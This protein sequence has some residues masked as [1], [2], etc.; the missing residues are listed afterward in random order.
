M[1]AAASSKQIY[2]AKE[3]QALMSRIWA[4]D[5]KDDP[6]AFVMYVYPWRKK[7]TPLE[8]MSGPRSWQKDVLCK[9]R[10]QIAENKRRIARGEV[11]LVLQVAISSGRGIGK[12]SLLA[13]ITHWQMSCVLGGMSIVTANTEDQLRSKTFGEVGKWLAL[14]INGHWFDKSAT[15]VRPAPWFAELLKSDLKI[16][17]GY[18]Y[19]Q[20]QTWSAE[21]PDAFAGAH[22]MNGTVVLMDEASGIDSTIW[23]VTEGFFTEPVLYRFWFVFSNPRRNTGS[24]FECFH[25]MR[26]FWWRLNIDSRKVEGTDKTVYDKIIAKY[27]EDSDEVRVEVKGEFPRQGDNQFIGRDLVMGSVERDLFEDEYAGL[28]MGV[29]PA[30]FGEDMT[31]VC[32]RRGRDCR[33]IP[34]IGW[35]GKDNMWVANMCAELIDKHGPDAVVVDAGNGTGIID[36]LR[37]MGYKVHEA[38]FGAKAQDEAY[39]NKR[40]ELWAKMRDWLNEGCLPNKAELIDDL[41]GPEYGFQGGGDKIILESKEKMKSRGLSSPDWADALACTFAVKVARLDSKLS[42]SKKNKQRV[43]KDM[44]FRF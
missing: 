29:D 5:I 26:Q 23:T 38:W 41:V 24:F 34:M 6:Y 19:C 9:M 31:T 20:A 42:R 39:A 17:T 44:D 22:N 11:P 40:T 35:K 2:S 12:S 25:K 27:G 7:G 33:S 4:A 10:D 3:E 15:A 1:S 21:N 30:R 37:E 32:F 13:W 8:K 16:D 36:R 14:A 43:A 18:Y 28:V